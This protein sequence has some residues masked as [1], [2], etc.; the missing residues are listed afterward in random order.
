MGDLAGL[1]FP[2]TADTG[3]LESFG[4]HA[5]KQLGL[6]QALVRES[7]A[8]TRFRDTLLPALMD[9]SLRVEDAIA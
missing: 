4:V 3:A 8:L 7:R 9:G 2:L 5:D 6:A 1:R